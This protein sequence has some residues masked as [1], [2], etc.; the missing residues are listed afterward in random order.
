MKQNGFKSRFQLF[1]DDL[2]EMTW[3][4]WL[5]VFFVA[6]LLAAKLYKTLFVD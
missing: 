2:K 5:A 4:K 1:I 6:V 3:K